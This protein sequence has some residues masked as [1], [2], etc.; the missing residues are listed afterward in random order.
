MA[1]LNPPSNPE[2]NAFGFSH[3]NGAVKD[4]L[5]IPQSPNSPDHIP[6]PNLLMPETPSLSFQ[7]SS[8][9][10]TPRTKDADEDDAIQPLTNGSLESSFHSA[11]RHR[12]RRPTWS[13][14]DAAWDKSYVFSFDGGGV[15]G[16]STLIILKRIM[17]RVKHHERSLDP[18]VQSSYHPATCPHDILDRDNSTAGY[19]PC[20]YIDYMAGTSTGG[21]IAIMLSRLRMDVDDTIEE[22]KRLASTIFGNPRKFSIRGPILWPRPKHD[23]RILEI[24]VR[25]LLNKRLPK[26]RH[27][28]GGQR[29][30][31]NQETCRTMV[32]A[33]GK[34]DEGHEDAH[35]FRSYDHLAPYH[36]NDSSIRNPGPADAIEIETVARATSAAPTYFKAVRVGNRKLGDG[37]FGCNNPGW[38]AFNEVRD[39]HNS[40]DE[41]VAL[42]IS[43]GTG[44][45]YIRRF[46]HAE[47]F[48]EA[49]QAI[50]AAKGIATDCHKVDEL[51][52][53]LTQKRKD[54]Y[55]RFNADERLGKIKLDCWKKAKGSRCSTADEIQRI[56]DEYL[57]DPEVTVEI[58]RVAQLLVHNRR[59]RSKTDI[60]EERLFGLQW[61]CLLENCPEGP[62]PRRRAG[63]EDH[64][65]LYH[66]FGPVALQPPEKRKAY[67]DLIRRGKM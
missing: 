47:G 15:R 21:L 64:L 38:E 19:Y 28:I 52:R 2:D 32:I 61:R 60:W 22:F 37:G 11:G 16:L 10:S 34:S 13:E 18:P 55:F 44:E 51:L 26:L 50:K 35:V 24:A 27:H 56:T 63:L 46:T 29:F 42:L 43:I 39:M 6:S 9:A 57:E 58:D 12:T 40:D 25:E 1:S 59:M 4:H 48:S 53:T 36:P 14:N 5:S 49:L 3:S 17:L 62:Q 41:G 23:Y 33:H 67:E 30:A 7:S 8:E 31:S 66:D 54:S 20:H 45:S 65:Q